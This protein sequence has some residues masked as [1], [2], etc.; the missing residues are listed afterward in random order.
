MINTNIPL[1]VVFKNF[2]GVDHSSD[3]G[4][5]TLDMKDP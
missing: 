2:K 4:H 3:S 1:F 5:V